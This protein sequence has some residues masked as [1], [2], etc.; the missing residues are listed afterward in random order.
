[1]ENHKGGQFPMTCT[2]PQTAANFADFACVIKD[3]LEIM[4]ENNECI[5][6]KQI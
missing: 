6:G 2:K 4:I 5:T 3:K 1:M